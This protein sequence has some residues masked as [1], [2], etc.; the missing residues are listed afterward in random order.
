[1]KERRD[2]WSR[3]KQAVEAEAETEVSELIAA[4]EKQDLEALEQKTDAEILEELGLP[5]PETLEAGDDFAAFMS[6]TVPNRLRNRAL[7]KLWLSD[8]MLA[9]LDAL[10]DYGEDFTINPLDTEV[11]QTT[12]QVGK[13]LLAHVKEMERQEEAA[14]ESVSSDNDVQEEQEVKAAEEVEEAELT[15]AEP[16]HDLE[17]QD[18][19]TILLSDEVDEVSDLDTVITTKKRM[20]FVFEA[21]T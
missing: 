7:R 1:M 12:Y 14:K 6:K 18:V 11:I 3:R 20:R 19:Q 2:F 15:F 9:N 17:E 13:G 4:E 5:D 21:Q 16:D 10:V 8:P